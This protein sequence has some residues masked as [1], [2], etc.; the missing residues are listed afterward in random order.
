M[1]E[2][3]ADTADGQH[4]I[5]DLG[6]LIDEFDARDFRHAERIVDVF[7]RQGRTAAGYPRIRPMDCR[8]VTKVLS[9][10]LESH[11]LSFRYGDER[12]LARFWKLAEAFKS[13]AIQAYPN[14]I[15]HLNLLL[16]HARFICGHFDEAVTII[17]PIAE[18][19]YLVEG[20]F[21]ALWRAFIIDAKARWALG[22]HRKAADASE[23]DRLTLLVRIRPL[24]AIRL[25]QDF[26]SFLAHDRRHFRN[27]TSLHRLVSNLA[28]S[29]MTQTRQS[30]NVLMNLVR[31][32]LR[33]GLDLFGGVAS[34]VAAHTRQYR[35]PKVAACKEGAPL[36]T[37]GGIVSLSRSQRETLVTRAMGG[38]GDLL[39]MSPGLRAL[40]QR[41][42]HP[43]K[44]AI[45]HQFFPLFEGNPHV[46]LIDMDGPAIDVARYRWRNLSR[47]PAASHESL[48]RPFIK[49][50]RV[51]LFAR[52]MGIRRNSLRRSGQKI[53]VFLSTDQVAFR[54]AW[55]QQRGLGRNKA[56]VGVQPHSREAYRDHPRI[57]DIILRL[58][59]NYDVV[60]FHQSD[61]P[62]PHTRGVFSTAGLSLGQSLALVSALDAMVC[63]D[64]A[65]LHAAAAFETPTVALFGPIDGQLRTVHMKNVTVLD[66]RASF[67]CVPCWR[68]ED[69]PCLVTGEVGVS[70]CMTAIPVDKVLAVVD[71]TIVHHLSGSAANV[72][73]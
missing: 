36:E 31:R 33:M 24:L 49:R 3:V 9:Q 61:L 13:S 56:L 39:M 14:E 73:G 54:D 7:K 67:G 17:G 45:K 38:I 11:Q 21:S 68:N 65:F 53:D 72:G 16:A 66:A 26:R 10:L 1:L 58:A 64:S 18:R 48:R 50:G 43:V 12:V 42:G 34:L 51:E 60:V 20:D 71:E 35:D 70:P 4:E 8:A 28:Y 41:Q 57:Y 23:F 22:R 30:G 62:L 6:R 69:Q 47:C 2:K 55:L 40:A 46:E 29:S 25:F 59:E 15:L 32:I 19:P 44:F 27:A 5:V 63:V 37:A 52:G